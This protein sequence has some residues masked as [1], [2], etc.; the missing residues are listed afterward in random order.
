MDT[1][2]PLHSVSVAGV[3]INNEGRALIIQRRDNGHWEPPGGVLHHGEPIK[4][5]LRREVYEETGLRVEPEQLT[6]VYQN[7]PRRIVA[8]VF[9]CRVLHGEPM[10]TPEAKAF[11]WVTAEQAR[12]FMTDAYAVR[13]V[14]ALVVGPTTAIRSHDGTYLRSAGESRSATIAATDGSCIGNP[15][16]GGWAWVTSDGRQDAKAAKHTNSSRM[17]LMA[18]LQLLEAIDDDPLTIQTDNA[19]VVGTFTGWLD[20]WRARGM[21]RSDGKPVENVDLIN[22]IDAALAGRSVT[23]EKVPAHAGHRLNE[24][25]NALAQLASRRSATSVAPTTLKQE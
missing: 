10:E 17:E 22:R 24:R 18:V 15:G 7:M 1:D 16:P 12:S 23:F 14:D 8:L 9:R 13:V 3:I 20:R 11:R 5:G 6:G 2:S 21:R 19:Y 25:A 4:D